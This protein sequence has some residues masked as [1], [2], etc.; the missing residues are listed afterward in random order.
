MSRRQA[1]RAGRD[2]EGWIYLIACRDPLSVKI[3]FTTKDPR[4]RLKQLQTGSP[5]T[6]VLMGWYPG[7]ENDERDLHSKLSAFRLTGEWFRVDERSNELLRA[8]CTAAQI[9]NALCG[10]NP[11]AGQ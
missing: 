10:Y 3:G 9:N 7:T 6:L 1:A 11:M 4:A 2:R 5:T 8:P